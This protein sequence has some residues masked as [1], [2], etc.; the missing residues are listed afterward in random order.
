[1]VTFIYIAL[2][3]KPFITLL[4]MLYIVQVLMKNSSLKAFLEACTGSSEALQC[5][6]HT[7][8]FY[9]YRHRGSMDSRRKKLQ[10]QIKIFFYQ[11]LPDRLF[12]GFFA[13]NNERILFRHLHIKCYVKTHPAV[14]QKHYSTNSEQEKK[15]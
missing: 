8:L 1:M 13:Q 3:K 10:H 2:K 9:V 4:K 14:Q 15:S 7:V 12:W 6:C 11:Q 5:M